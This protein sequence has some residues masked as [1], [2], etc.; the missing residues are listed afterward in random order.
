MYMQFWSMQVKLPDFAPFRPKSGSLPGSDLNY[1]A[2]LDEGVAGES[3]YLSDRR[4]NRE[5]SDL[6]LDLFNRSASLNAGT[7]RSDEGRGPGPLHP[8]QL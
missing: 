2:A 5:A 7:S 8:R 1:L 4:L 3:S 6:P